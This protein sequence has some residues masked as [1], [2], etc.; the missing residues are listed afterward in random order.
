[1]PNKKRGPTGPVFVWLSLGWMQKRPGSTNS[2]SEFGRRRRPEGVSAGGANQSPRECQMNKR[3]PLWPPFFILQFLW[4]ITD[5]RFETRP[6]QPADRRTSAASAPE[7]RAADQRVSPRESAVLIEI[8]HCPTAAFLQSGQSISLK[9]AKSNVRYRPLAA[10]PRKR[11]PSDWRSIWLLR[12]R[13]RVFS[14][15][16]TQP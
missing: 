15:Q 3:R 6:A 10:L 8:N 1:M 14:A 16:T 2:R 5:R 4:R 13:S 7:G 12:R 9:S 11:S